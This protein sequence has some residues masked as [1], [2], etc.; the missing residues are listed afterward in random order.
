MSVEIIV[1][2]VLFLMLVGIG[3]YL[4]IDGLRRWRRCNGACSGAEVR[5][6]PP[7][8]ATLAARRARQASAQRGWRTRRQAGNNPGFQG[9]PNETTKGE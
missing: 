6:V 7:A 5:M 3:T 4:L 1:D 9:I 2:C 8:A